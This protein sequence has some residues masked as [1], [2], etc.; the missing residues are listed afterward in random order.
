MS[1]ANE[2]AKTVYAK[3]VS[4]PKDIWVNT[5]NI[6]VPVICTTFNRHNC[7]LLADYC[8][9]FFKYE[10]RFLDARYMSKQEKQHKNKSNNILLAKIQKYIMYETVHN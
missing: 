2:H 10:R 9:Y 4:T 3:T 5:E 6:C 8:L 1:I 7:L